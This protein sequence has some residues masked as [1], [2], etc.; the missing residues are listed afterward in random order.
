MTDYTEQLREWEK[1]DGQRPNMAI[2]FFGLT[3]IAEG[4]A[5]EVQRLEEVVAKLPRTADGVP[6]VPGMPVYVNWQDA[7]MEQQCVFAIHTIQGPGDTGALFYDDVVVPLQ[8]AYSTPEAALAGEP[9][10]GKTGSIIEAL[11][12]IHAA[13]G[14]AW[15]DI[16]DPE[17]LIAEM[18]GSHI[19][20]P[21]A[22]RI[23]RTPQSVVDA[24][25]ALGGMPPADEP[26]EKC[27]GL[28]RVECVVD[29]NMRIMPGYEGKPCSKCGH[30]GVGQGVL[31]APVCKV[32]GDHGFVL[33][34]WK[35]IEDCPE[36]G[37][38]G[39]EQKGKSDD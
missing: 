31:D 22:V 4:L 38:T 39:I 34:D 8:D 24:T 12:R 33:V 37:H 14:K 27:G 9:P 28:G 21:P 17:A 3:E 26:C 5:A 1:N 7:D 30:T 11:D 2:D 16:E 23:G 25:E 10:H 20:E 6:V 18:R 19:G 35:K 29:G 13:G 15:D 36:C 32:C